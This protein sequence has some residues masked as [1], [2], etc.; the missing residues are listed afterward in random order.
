MRITE[1]NSSI[2]SDYK[3][4]SMEIFNEDWFPLMKYSEDYGN[5]IPFYDLKY[6]SVGL[7]PSLTAKAEENIHLNIF[8]INEKYNFKNET[9]F[10][11]LRHEYYQKNQIEI[12]RKL[13]DYQKEIKY[14]L[15]QIPYFKLLIDFFNSIEE[16]DTFKQHVFHY[17]FCQLRHTDSKRIQKVIVKKENYLMLVQ[18]FKQIVEITKPEFVFVF[19]AFLSG[20]LKDNDFFSSNNLDENYGCYFMN[21]SDYISPKF[22]LANQL[23]GGATSNIYKDLLIWNTKRILKKS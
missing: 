11:G 2:E 14:G 3:V 15:K 1:F 21:N 23:S 8:G 22:I 10:G 18:H 9:K 13:I 12:D 4:S 5:L 17:D 6:I 7:N 19:N 20:L 16:K